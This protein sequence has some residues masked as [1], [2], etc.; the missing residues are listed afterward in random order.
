MSDCEPLFFFFLPVSL[1]CCF[2]LSRLIFYRNLD[3]GHLDNVIPLKSLA[4][5]LFSLNQQVPALINLT[6]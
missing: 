3:T 5:H 4:A 2:P 6:R 1:H